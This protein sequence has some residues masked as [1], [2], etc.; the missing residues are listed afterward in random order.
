MLGTHALIG[1]WEGLITV[2]AC[3]VFARDEETSS[4]WSVA[5]P[6]TAAVVIGMMLSPF[7]SGF[8]DGLE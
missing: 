3:L 7:A 2:A 4:K 1:I 5:A 8:P 6:L